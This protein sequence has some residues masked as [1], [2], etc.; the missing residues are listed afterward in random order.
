METPTLTQ[1]LS[2]AEEAEAAIDPDHFAT[3]PQGSADWHTLRREVLELTGSEFAQAIGADENVSPVSLYNKKKIGS[4][5]PNAF[6][7]KMLDYGNKNE[8]N[9]FTELKLWLPWIYQSKKLKLIETGTWVFLDRKCSMGSSPDGLLYIENELIGVIEI[10]CPYNQIPYP[11]L[12]L[13]PPL[14]KPSHYVQIQME[15]SATSSQWAAYCVWTPELSYICII[16][17][18]E[19]FQEEVL[20]GAEN[21]V[22]N[23][24]RKNNPPPRR[25][26]GEQQGWEERISYSCKHTIK[27]VWEARKNAEGGTVL[28]IKY[29]NSTN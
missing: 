29:R 2:Q 12:E 4:P 7:Q 13:T 3:I 16:E 26:K 25:L 11:C 14:V 1:L 22:L 23:Y 27:E 6:V 10:K 21:F 20:R 8:E 17:R 9:A 28:K 15:L 5:T 19:I 24:L 18:D